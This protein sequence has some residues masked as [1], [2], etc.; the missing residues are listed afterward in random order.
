[1]N[2]EVIRRIEMMD[3]WIDILESMVRD[4]KNERNKIILEEK[5]KNHE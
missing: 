1:M 3:E 4:I 2:Q 5:E